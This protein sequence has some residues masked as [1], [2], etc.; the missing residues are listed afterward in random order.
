MPRCA[1][2]SSLRPPGKKASGS[3]SGSEASRE[4]GSGRGQGGAAAAAGPEVVC[5]E[6]PFPV[7]AESAGSRRGRRG[8]A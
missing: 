3:G 1:S 7:S 8:L 5:S 2:V 4:G 6:E